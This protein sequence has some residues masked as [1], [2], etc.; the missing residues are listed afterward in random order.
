MEEILRG[1][2]LRRVTVDG[3][4]AIFINEP[5]LVRAILVNDSRNYGR[6]D[7]FQKGRNISRAGLLLEDESAHRH[8]RRLANPFLRA[9]KVDEYV[10]TMRG[11][12]HD[13][14]ASWRAGHAVDIQTEMCWIT[15]AI[16]LGSLFPGPS[17]ETSVAL[18]DR[19][20]VLTWETARKPLYGKAAAPRQGPSA[21]QMVQAREDVRKLFLSQ[22]HEQ[23]R[24]PASASGYLSVLLSDSDENGDRILTVDQVCDEAVMM[25]IAA[26]ATTASVLSWALYVLSDEPSIEEK[27]LED[28]ARGGTECPAHGGERPSYTVRFL[29][30]VLRLYPPIWITCRKTRA[31]VTL[32]DYSLPEGMNVIFSSYMLHRDP[33]RYPDPTRFDPD[34]W[35]S[36]RPGFADGTLYIPFGIGARACIGEPFAWQELDVILGAVM[37]GWRLRTEPGSRVHAAAETTLHPHELLMIPQSR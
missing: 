34:R 22:I 18:S 5:D 9:A 29:M 30:E 17:P 10:P 26:A 8:Y 21:P 28:M 27:L 7:V 24:S 23:L 33:D 15:S 37:R 13:A 12:A 19:L 32:G 20:A 6:G 36:V 14:V 16:G 11:I 31:S 4:D 3:V 1:H 35:L 25:L 2:P